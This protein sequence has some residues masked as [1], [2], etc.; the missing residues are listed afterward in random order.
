L[1]G[2]LLAC[3]RCRRRLLVRDT[4]AGKGLRYARTRGGADHAE[5][6][7]PSL[8]GQRLDA[9]VRRPVRTALA[10]AALEWHRAAAAAGGQER[11]RRH[12]HGQQQRQR[13]ASPTDRAAR[14]YQAVAAG[15]RFVARERER[16]W[17]AA[18]ADPRR[19]DAADERLCA[20]PPP[21]LTAAAREQIRSLARD[22]PGLWQAATTTAADRQRLVRFRVERIAIGVPGATGQAAVARHGA[23]GSVRHPPRVRPVP[24]YDRMADHARPGARIAALRAEGRSMTAVAACLNRAG[25]HPP[26]RAARLGSALGAGFLAT[27]GRSGPRPRALAAAGLRR[28]GE[29][30]LSDLARQLGM[31][32]AAQPSWRQLGRVQAPKLPVPGGHGAI[33]AAGSERKRRTGLRQSRRVRRDLPIPAARPPR[34][35]QTRT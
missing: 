21:P 30:L 12:R 33:W 29:G 19:L 15:S 3:G 26:Q 9:L 22:L 14:P 31:P 16:R 7:C 11:Q 6:P 20:S 18:L 24:R 2:G 1:L 34:H 32:P 28:K 27:G 17:E 8:S 13:A 5:P 25:F 10:P 4:N 23:G 35:A